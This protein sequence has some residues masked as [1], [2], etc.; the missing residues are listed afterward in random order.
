MP[1]YLFVAV[2]AHD[3]SW[4]SG[5]QQNVPAIMHRHGGEFVAASDVV[6]R[7]EGGGDDPNRAVLMKF[8]TMQAIEAFVTD[9]EYAPYRAARLAASTSDAFAFATLD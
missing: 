3:L 7:Y 8:P 1:A 6:K 9:P 2:A 5:Y 4:T